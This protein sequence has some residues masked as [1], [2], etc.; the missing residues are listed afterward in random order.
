MTTQRD[1]YDILGVERGATDADIKRA[2][3]KLAQQWHPD[4]NR[5]DQAEATK[6]LSFDDFIRVKRMTALQLSPDDVLESRKDI[7][8]N[9]LCTDSASVRYSND[10]DN[11]FSR[12]HYEFNWMVVLT[13][14]YRAWIIQGLMVTLKISAISIVLS[15]LLG[16]I[17]TTLRMTK[18]RVV[19]WS[20]L[21]YIE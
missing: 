17:V 21:S 20:C 8:P 12:Y 5:A 19:E 9:V 2:F 18:I 7:L 6:P 11:L 14:E 1:Y 3:R 10:L 13:G 4:V 15:L 16:T